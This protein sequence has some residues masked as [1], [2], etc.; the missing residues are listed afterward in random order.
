MMRRSWA[1][2]LGRKRSVPGVCV[3]CWLLL[4]FWCLPPLL[5][6]QEQDEN[7][8]TTAPAS[9]QASEDDR[10]SRA[11]AK[12]SDDDSDGDADSWV[13]FPVPAYQPESGFIGG[14][15]IKRAFSEVIDGRG[16][17]LLLSGAYTEKRQ[18]IFFASSRFYFRETGFDP[19]GLF[20]YQDWP[21]EFF[22]TGNET[23]LANSENYAE[24][25]SRLELRVNQRIAGPFGGLLRYRR[26]SNRFTQWVE[27]G[28]LDQA[29][30]EEEPQEQTAHGF[31]V[32]LFYDSRDSDSDPL[33]GM[34]HQITLW[35]E[36]VTPL[37][38]AEEAESL[39]PNTQE[40][41]LDLRFYWPLASYGSFAL[42]LLQRQSQGEASPFWAWPYLG[43][44]K[45]LRGY[46]KRRFAGRALQLVQADHRYRFQESAFGFGLFYGAGRVAE[47]VGDLDAQ[48]WHEAWG[49]EGIYYVDHP[50]HLR[51][52]VAF[53]EGQTSFYALFNQ[54]Y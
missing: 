34:Y 32:G 41:A 7:S 33:R 53:A 52:D 43:G 11:S 3:A 48:R 19:Q 28:L 1:G 21:A 44:D 51:V 8:D 49:V 20:L 26:R 29:F 15:F 40:Q 14:V 47:R 54:P 31:G 46:Y 5:Q 25:F 30:A 13:V 39:D 18:S 42:Q 10:G 45:W 37:L 6:A 35:S 27:D 24:Q 38:A 16:D 2:D 4:A 36:N 12:D 17:E 9:S 50:T 22:G 23:K